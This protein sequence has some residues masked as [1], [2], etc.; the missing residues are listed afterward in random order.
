VTSDAAATLRALEFVRACEQI[1][2][3]HSAVPGHGLLTL[4]CLGRSVD[5]G[6]T[7]APGNAI[8]PG[9]EVRS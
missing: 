3:F 6:L 5:V 1:P 8:K 7:P 4:G 9:T 2:P